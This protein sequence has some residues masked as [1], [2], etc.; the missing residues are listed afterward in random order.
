MREKEQI[1]VINQFQ[2]TLSI[3]DKTMKKKLS[4]GIGLVAMGVLLI[5]FINQRVPERAQTQYVFTEVQ[6]GTLTLSVSSTGTL[7]ARETIEVGTQ[8]SGMLEEVR[9]DYNDAVRQGQLLALIETEALDANLRDAEAGLARAQAQLEE[10]E[11]ELARNQP[12]HASGYI[13]E[14]EFQPIRTV[15]ASAEASVVSAEAA[16]AKAKQNRRNA[17]IRA[18]IDGVVIERAVE[19]GQTVAASFNTPRLF[20]LAES[21]EQMEILVDVDESDIGLITPGM[22][23]VFA[24]PAY[25]EQLFIGMTESIRLQPQTIQ[26]VVTYTVVVRAEN[27]DGK[28]LPGMTATVDFQVEQVSNVLYVPLATLD[29]RPTA[30]MRDQAPRGV[31]AN[32]DVLPV[33][34]L[35]GGMPEGMAML[36]YQAEAQWHAI[37]VMQGLSD[38]IYAEVTPLG[39]GAS[40]LEVGLTVVERVQVNKGKDTRLPGFLPSREGPRGMNL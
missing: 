38:G 10:A 29:V 15:R 19:E 14:R 35:D 23:V 2:N 27:I 17:E 33:R 13:S 24:V 34:D 22:P 37:P 11:A 21:L 3:P 32:A 20:V 4:I 25:P 16:V 8:V 12:L 28:L 40:A 7:S 36:W 18:P 6:R 39:P 9:I 31:E 5:G 26:N 30:A 1:A